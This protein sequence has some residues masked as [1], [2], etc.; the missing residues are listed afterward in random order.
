MKIS[1]TNERIYF[2]SGEDKWSV[3]EPGRHGRRTS[4]TCRMPVGIPV[5][6]YYLVVTCPNYLTAAKKLSLIRWAI[7]NVKVGETVEKRRTHTKRE[8]P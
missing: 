8:K 3:A 4:R 2:T 6:W 7:R 1:R 5:D